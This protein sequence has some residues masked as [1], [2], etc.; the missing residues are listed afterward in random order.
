MAQIFFSRRAFGRVAAATAALASIRAP[1]AE[2]DETPFDVALTSNVMVPMRD[3][4]KLATDVYRP[5]RYGKPVA[6]DPADRSGAD[7]GVKRGRALA[8]NLARHDAQERV[9]ATISEPI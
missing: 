3:G 6:R 7:G 5:A 1:A 9:T 4:V 2:A 8:R